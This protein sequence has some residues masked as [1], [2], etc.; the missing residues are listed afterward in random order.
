MFGVALSILVVLY[1]TQI[2][3]FENP[4]RGRKYTLQIGR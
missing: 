4:T 3:L 1:I 2:G